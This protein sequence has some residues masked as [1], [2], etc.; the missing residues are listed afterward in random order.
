M[1]KFNIKKQE[2]E[3]PYKFKPRVYQIPVVRAFDNGK[4]RIVDIEHR[5][6]GKDILWWNISI[7]ETQR[8]IGSYYY[9]FPQLKQ[10][11]R[12]IWEGTTIEGKKFIDY[13]PKEIIEGDPNNLDMKI[14]FK[15]GSI[16]QLVGSDTFK[17]TVG[18]NPIGCVFSEYS[19]QDPSGWLYVM[20]I[21]RIN[22][23]WAV[24]NFT[25]RGKNHGYRILNIAKENPDEWFWQILT[26]DDTGVLTDEDIAKEI[27]AGMSKAMAMQE[28]KCFF[29]T[30]V[31]GAYYENELFKVREEGRICGVPINTTVPVMTFWDLGFHDY[32][33][34]WFAQIIGK[35][36]HLVD[37][38]QNCGMALSHYAGYMKD[39]KEKHS[40]VLGEL[41]LPHDAE[42]RRLQTGTSIV[43]DLKVYGFSAVSVERPARKEI[44]IEY[45]RQIFSQLWFDKQKCEKGIDALSSYRK[46]YDEKNM[47]FSDSPVHDWSSHSSDAL[48]TLALYFKLYTPMNTINF[49]DIYGSR[50]VNLLEQKSPSAE[51]AWMGN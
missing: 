42:E 6:A 43:E 2:I 47:M 18:P 29:D 27:K 39:W 19:I 11:K 33:S 37:F 23:G 48:Q 26:I 20:P 1:N 21:L 34:V 25:P 30:P 44:G 40:C 4:K 16:L 31:E 49:K 10:A 32:T 9:F 3:L 7:R 15:N 51:Y 28:Y 41:M 12:T 22:K 36:I 46:N 45:V 35:E 5:K 14:R 50:V 17:E 24:F 13:V 8:R 38:Y